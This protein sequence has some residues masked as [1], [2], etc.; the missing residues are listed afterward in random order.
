MD[1]AD[2]GQSVTIRRGSA[3]LRIPETAD[4]TLR[5][6]QSPEVAFSATK[7]SISVRNL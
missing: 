5:P 4:A 7:R 1:P 6:R 3:S 2:R